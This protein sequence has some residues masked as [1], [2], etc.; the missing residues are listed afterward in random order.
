MPEELQDRFL[1]YQ[2][3]VML[4]PNCTKIEIAYDIARFN[5]CRPMNVAQNG[6]TVLT[7]EFAEYVDNILKMKFFK[8]DS[9]VSS[10]RESNNTSGMIVES[11]MVTYFYENFSKDFRKICDFL[12]ENANDTIFIEFYSMVERLSAVAKESVSHLFNTR[13]SFLWFGLFARFIKTGLNDGKFIEFMEEFSTNLYYKEVNGE[14]YEF[15]D[16][17]STKDR[18]IVIHKLNHLEKLMRE[19]LH[20]NIEETVTELLEFIQEQVNE[21][22]TQEDLVCYE[23]TLHDLIQRVD[24]G[25]KLLER[26]NHVS[27][28]AM[29]AY[30]YVS[31]IDLDDWFVDYFNHNQDYI[32]NQKANFITMKNSMEQYYRLAEKKAV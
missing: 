27:L 30:S 1:D 11:I 31:Y 28:L 20:I 24:H 29:V 4:N 32:L 7:E 16:S 14:S 23:D 26:Q 17:K 21:D 19:Y 9:A 8:E 22:A 13:D 10:Y 3:P 6:W 18:F 2:V 15:L 25:S 5:R 12:S